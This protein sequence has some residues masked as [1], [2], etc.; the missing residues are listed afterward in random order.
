MLGVKRQAVFPPVSG[1][2]VHE[3]RAGGKSR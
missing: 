2:Y 3:R 1:R